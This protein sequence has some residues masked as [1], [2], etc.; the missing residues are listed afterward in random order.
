MIS[1]NAERAAMVLL[2]LGESAPSGMALKELASG[3]GEGKPAV[4]R[5]LAALARHGFVEQ[6]GRGRYR[7][8]PSVYALARREHSALER[9]QRWRPAL[10]TLAQHFGHCIYLMGRAGLDAVV[11]DMHVGPAPVQALT[12]GIGGR[13][14]LGV[15]P[16]SIAILST[17]DADDRRLIMET[18]T[19]RY[20]ERKVEPRLVERLVAGA[21]ARGHA[22]DLGDFVAGCG[23]IA[24]PVRERNGSCSTAIT[25]AAPLAFLSE[26][27][28]ADILARLDR[29]IAERA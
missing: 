4:H 21:V 3:L 28:I 6:I 17:L 15:G 25:V 24:V 16:G 13:L 27:N 12:S 7:L 26:E 11:L 19:P 23:G 20:R 29:V 14:P 22:R 1:T 9:I 2:K 8:G 18:N 5:T 10:M